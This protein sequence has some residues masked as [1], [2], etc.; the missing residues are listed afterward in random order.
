MVKPWDMAHRAIKR[1]ALVICIYR[2]LRPLGGAPLAP[3]HATPC[4]VRRIMN[5]CEKQ[6]LLLTHCLPIFCRGVAC[7]ARN[8]ARRAAFPLPTPNGRQLKNIPLKP[9]QLVGWVLLAH[10]E[11]MG[12]GALRH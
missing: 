1:R 2:T 12:H 5:R 9:H 8:S 7:Y 4:A 6:F 11:T 10:G 3:Q